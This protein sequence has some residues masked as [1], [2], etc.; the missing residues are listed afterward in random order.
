MRRIWDFFQNEN[1]D[2]KYI[3]PLSNRALVEKSTRFNKQICL[4]QNH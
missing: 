4:H 2:L 1:N 3:L